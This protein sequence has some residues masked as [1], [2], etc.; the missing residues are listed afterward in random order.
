MALTKIDDRGLK[1]PIDL[2]DN[3]KIRFGTGNDL[4]IYHDG[5]HNYIKGAT[6]GQYT[7]LQNVSGSVYIQSVAGENSI[8][9]G[10]NGAVELYYDGSKKFETNAAGIL[11]TG[12]ITTGDNNEVACGANGDLKLYHNGTNSY[13]DNHQGDLYIRGEDDHIVLQ[14]VDGESAIVCDPNG[15]VNLYYDNSQKFET[16]STGTNVTGVHVDDGATHDGDVSFNGAS[17]NSWWDKSDSAFKFDDNAKIK[18][19]TG[20]DLQIYHDG[21]NTQINNHTGSLYFSYAGTESTIS[22]NPNGSVDLYYDAVKKF[23]TTSAGITVSGNQLISQSGSTTAFLKLHNGDDTDGA[24]F[25]YSSSSNAASIQVAQSGSGFKIFCGGVNAGNRRFQAYSDTTATVIPYGDENMGVFTPN[26]AVELYYDNSKRVQT[27]STGTKFLATDGST[28]RGRV[29]NTVG[30]IGM[31]HTVYYPIQIWHD[32]TDTQ[33]LS[34]SFAGPAAVINSDGDKA[35]IN[36]VSHPRHRDFGAVYMWYGC[37]SNS[38]GNTFDW[39]FTVYNAQA[40]SGYS[41]GSTTFTVTTGS[42]SNGQLKK[43]DIG[44]SM[45]SCAAQDMVKVKIE[46]DELQAGTQIILMGM[47]VTEYTSA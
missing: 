38:T 31:E 45:P 29:D 23:E 4:Q 39:D 18:V 24:K 11:V 3:E 25:I 40:N 9:C 15:A 7:Y 20:G 26:G 41:S 44:S 2:L 34:L 37:S 30:V 28:V 5:T 6:S 10:V 27:Q 36:F 19:G 35:Y 16:T 8:W 22:A 42:M 33:T 12:N 17:Y 32:G 46:Y 14:P 21:T 43:F 47:Q 13:I 1:T